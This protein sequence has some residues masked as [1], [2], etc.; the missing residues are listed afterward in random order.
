MMTVLITGGK[1]E[2][3][4][5]KCS[6]PGSTSNWNVVDKIDWD[7]YKGQRECARVLAISA[8]TIQA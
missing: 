4:P 5:G 1:T 6:A 8:R 7:N 3:N 2:G